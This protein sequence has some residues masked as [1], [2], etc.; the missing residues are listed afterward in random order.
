MAAQNKPS[1]G[2]SRR[3]FLQGTAGAFALLP[4]AHA[5]GV[6]PE[7]LIT[8]AQANGG[9]LVFAAESMGETL[10]T[11]LWNGFG[12]I[13]VTD[14]MGE[15]LIRSNFVSGEPTPGLAESWTISDDGLTYTFTLRSGATF[16]DGTPVTAPAVVRSFTRMTDDTDP[17]YIPG[18]YMASGHGSTNF[19]SMTALDDMTLELVLNAPDAT[20]LHRLA[21]PSAM[22]ISPAALDAQTT[23]VGTMP[24]MAGP[25]ALERFV[26][27]Q[28]AVL[29]A[30]DGYYGGR[31]GVDTL[32]IRAY[33]DEASI[34][35][36]LE[37]GEVQ[38]TLYA[39]F[40]AVPRLQASD[41]VA[42]DVGAPFVDLFLGCNCSLELTG[43]LDI[44]MAIN[45]AIN[46]ETLI[47]GALNGFGE[48]PAS[49]LS[50]TDLG[51]D[52]S[53]RAVSTQNLELAAQHLAASGVATPIAI[54]LSYENNRFW[55]LIA[56]LVKADLDA[57]GFDVTLDPLDPGS[58]WG[59]AGDGN[60]QLGLNQRST[61]VPDPNDKATILHSV[62]S[63]G[64]L[65]YHETLPTAAELDALIDAGI[66]ELD[67]TARVEIYR[68]IQQMAIDQ[69][70]YVYLAY[71]TP[72]VFYARTLANVPSDSASSG[73]VNL[74]GVTFA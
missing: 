65:T 37:A 51:F 7:R 3:Q 47:I 10:E 18:L 2:I 20:Q 27:G 74:N 62:T 9:T 70:M 43:N 4:L 72:P 36:A 6:T 8:A 69:M 1:R 30:F 22:P 41:S 58:F 26:P 48:L 19:A 31:P 45:Y 44:R 17:S 29:R 38:F 55:P 61:F 66:A 15:G 23:D 52:E 73:R 60:M 11:G 33:P 46:R 32:V 53:F 5:A 39:P 67:P 57:V 59:K 54:E 68:Q 40:S 34:L 63:P 35:A 49:I 50:P 42:V 16:H 64:A 12:S 56:Q 71:L 28:E 25:F 21:R 13:H 24:V 14:N